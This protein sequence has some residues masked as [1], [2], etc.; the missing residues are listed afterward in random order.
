[1]KLIKYITV[2]ILGLNLVTSCNDLDLG[3]ED[4]YGSQNF[5]KTEAQAKGF[6]IGVHKQFRDN[7]VNYWKLGEARGGLFKKTSSSL[8]QSQDYSAIKSQNL[9]KDNTGGVDNWAGFYTHILNINH[10]ISQL[11]K[12]DYLSETDKRY[13]LGQVHGLRAWYYFWLYRTYGGVPINNATAVIDKVPD[14]SNELYL[15]RSTP[16]QTLDFIKSEIKKSEDYFGDSIKLIKSQWSVYATKMLKAEVY[17]WSAKVTTKD[18]VPE[19]TDLAT[20]EESLLFVRNSGRNFSLLSSFESVFSNNNKENA[21]IIF[22]IPFVENEATNF[23]NTFIYNPNDFTGRFDANGV[24]IT[25]N[26]PLNI[27]SGAGIFR[28]EYEFSLY[29]QF[30]AEDTRRDFTF[31]DFYG[32]ATLEQPGLALRKYLGS[33]NSAGVRIWVSDVPVYRYS[34]VLLMLAEVENKKGGDPSVYINEVRQRAYGRAYNASVHAY[35]H[36]TFENG[37]LT[38]LKERDKEFVAENKRWFDLLR[39]QDGSGNPLVFSPLANYVDSNTPI[40]DQTKEGY[41]VLW[42]INKQVIDTDPQVEQTP[43]Y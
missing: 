17:L 11:E 30:D 1:M 32:T 31:Y 28:N 16:K 5:W 21:E 2:A 23:Y 19:A 9:T 26:D 15:A 4:Y 27:A 40:L 41:K 18:Q 7:Y 25:T 13:L 36:T 38:I 6:V 20:A 37:E 43:G 35:R 39:L 33:V 3:P 29:Q 10:A 8:G 24:S 34:E 14:S 22:T 42:P 12:A